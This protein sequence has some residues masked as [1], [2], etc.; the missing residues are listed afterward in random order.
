VAKFASFILLA[1]LLVAAAGSGGAKALGRDPHVREMLL[2]ATGAIVGSLGALVPLGMARGAS[3]ASAA[4]AAL[5]AT[6]M[7]MV[8]ALASAAAVVFTLNPDAAFLYWTAGFYWSTLVAVASAAIRSVRAA[9][10]G[11]RACAA[12]QLP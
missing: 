12:S 4:Q 2:A 11:T 8:I 5:L 1:V 7:H 10:A 3:Q 6:V 9:A